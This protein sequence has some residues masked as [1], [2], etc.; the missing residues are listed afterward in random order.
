MTSF[1]NYF[2]SRFNFDRKYNKFFYQNRNEKSIENYSNRD[3]RFSYFS[4]NAYI[5]SRQKR[6]DRSFRMK[7]IIKIEKTS[8][9]DR[10][11]NRDERNLSREKKNKYSN[12]RYRIRNDATFNFSKIVKNNDKNKS[13]TKTYL[14]QNE[15]EQ[16]S[17]N[18]HENYHQSENLKYFDFDYDKKN[19][20]TK[21][22]IS[23]IMLFKFIC[24]KC[25]SALKLNNALHRHLKSCIERK[26][27][28]IAISSNAFLITSISIRKS[29]VD[30]NKDIDSE[31]N[32]REYQYAFID[33]FLSE[34][35]IFAFV[36]VDI[37]VDIT[38]TNTKFFKSIAK[39]VSIRTIIISITIRD[40]K[41]NKHF[42]VKY[43]IVSMYFSEKNEKREAVKTKITREVHLM[44]NLKT[45]MLIK[46][47]ILKSKKF[48]IF[49]FTSSAY[50]ESCETVISIF[51]KNRSAFRT[52]SVHFTKTRIISFHVEI[53]ILI[54]KILLFER[55]YLFESAETN[56]FIYSYIVDTITN[57]ILVRNNDNR[58]IRILKN[59]RLNKLIELKHFNALL[60]DFDSSNLA[61]RRSK[62]E[63]KNS[64][65]Q[66]VFKSAMI[67]T[68]ENFA[69]DVILSNEITVHKSSKFVVENFSKLMNDFAFLQTDQK[70]SNLF[71]KNWMRLSLKTNW[72][73]KIKEKTK[74]YSLRQRDKIVINETFNKLHSQNRLKWTKQ[75]TLFSFSVFV[76]WRDSTSN[77]KTRVVVDIRKLNAVF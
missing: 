73:F 3:D 20:D 57:V 26:T 48:D 32:F 65:F 18:D 75:N 6:N 24:R 42:T 40:L 29:N 36:C 51:I 64:F 31:Y 53:S 39:N 2:A 25:K 54:H 1:R 4:N 69:I 38:L 13:K 47:D 58:L 46:N 67:A 59:C 27:Y 5:I 35:D 62:S 76:I 44:N 34:N 30:V 22:T 28:S 15:I 63:H 55:D 7:I 8:S 71:E 61:I 52:T 12:N 70:F 10:E 17:E 77:K 23:L 37:E 66:K 60:I 74:I 45:N 11:F 19:D 9:S 16:E 68:A 43:V 56:F 50:I 72:E 49:T 21:I 33:I 14:T 41:I